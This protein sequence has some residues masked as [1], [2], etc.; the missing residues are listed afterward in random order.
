MV[1]AYFWG[2]LFAVQADRLSAGDKLLMASGYQAVKRLTKIAT[3][4]HHPGYHL[5]REHF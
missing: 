2:Y 1:G 5:G 3:Q 4:V